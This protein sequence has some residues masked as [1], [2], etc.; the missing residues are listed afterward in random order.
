MTAVTVSVL[1]IP[2]LPRRA[3]AALLTVHVAVSVGWLGLDGALVA[4]EVTSLTSGDP[5][6]QGGI[7][8]AMGALASWVLIP[9]VFTSLVSGLVLALSTPWGL[10]RHWWVL[11]KCGIAVTLTATGLALMLPR[12]GQVAIEDGEPIQLQTLLV[13][14]LAL[15]LLLAATGLSVIKPWGKTPHGRAAQ[16]TAKRVSR[17][18]DTEACRPVRSPRPVPSRR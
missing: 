3:R 4:L 18:S 17:S 12:L 15:V 5:A 9:V 11:A 1:A 6:V 14:S 7:E 2:R 10:V 13:R 8:A 16:V